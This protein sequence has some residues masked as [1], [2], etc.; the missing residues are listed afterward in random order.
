MKQTSGVERVAVYGTGKY[1]KEFVEQHHTDVFICAIFDGKRESG[2]FSGYPIFPL[3]KAS[4]LQI[5]KIIVASGIRAKRIIYDRISLFCKENN[6]TLFD[7]N[8]YNLFDLFCNLCDWKTKGFADESRLKKEINQHDVISFDIFDTLLVREVLFPV[9]VFDVVAKQ[10]E[11][12]GIQ[13]NGFKFDRITAEENVLKGKGEDTLDGIYQELQAM[14]GLSDQ[15]VKSLKEL[16]LDIESKII[17]P[18]Q[19]VVDMFHYA[20]SKGKK[21]CLTTDMYLP[22]SFLRPLLEKFSVSGYDKLFIS[23]FEGCGKTDGLFSRMK[24][25]LPAASYLHIGDNEYVDG[26]SARL[27]GVDAFLLPS[28]IESF[29]R[30]HPEWFWAMDSRSEYHMLG[31]FIMDKYQNPFLSERERNDTVYDIY[32]F[33]QLYLAPLCTGFLLWLI[34]Q[35]S[36]KKYDKVLFAARDGYIFQQLYEWYR[37]KYGGGGGN[38]LP[39]SEYLYASRKAL[40]R[41]A[42]KTSEE[43]NQVNEKWKNIGP[44]DFYEGEEKAESNQEG[45]ENY[46]A[47]IHVTK[48]KSYAFV[49]FMSGGTAQYFL[50]QVSKIS[51]DGYYLKW[52]K[53]AIYNLPKINSYM[54]TDVD[55]LPMSYNNEMRT[56]ILENVFSSPEPSTGGYGK[57]GTIILDQEVRTEKQITWM[58][59]AQQ[60]IADYFKS[61]VSVYHGD[62]D[63]VRA[64]MISMIFEEY[65]NLTTECFNRIFEGIQ[66]YDDL[67]DKV[68]LKLK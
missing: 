47:S 35:F 1:A 26:I 17:H 19:A 58:K 14:L 53:G 28:P 4:E 25:E 64:S 40:M 57:K 51:V 63:G 6:I 23:G 54:S 32:A 33:S 27:A 22:E 38:N 56:F 34:R 11:T 21:I 20:K 36:Q 55:R 5:T 46:L 15:D 48:G 61:F 7:Q 12:K 59:K 18:R 49:E 43:F 10:A 3:K 52:Y 2:I 68:F 29:K 16:E 30:N 8:G 60:S 62:C 41:A 44:L 50:Q 37:E 66:L 13:I 42:V 9:N 39:P 24:A 31:R 45:L 65:K 67:A